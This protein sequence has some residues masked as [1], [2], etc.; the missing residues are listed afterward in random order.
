[1]E[2]RD[3]NLKRIG[4]AKA[5]LLRLYRHD[6]DSAEFQRS[7]ER[8]HGEAA[9][10]DISIDDVDTEALPILE[11]NNFFAPNTVRPALPVEDLSFRDIFLAWRAI[12]AEGRLQID[13]RPQIHLG[14]IGS[15]A[16]WSGSKWVI[17]QKQLIQKNGVPCFETHYHCSFPPGSEPQTTRDH[18]IIRDY[19]RWIT[20]TEWMPP[21]KWPDD[22]KEACVRDNSLAFGE[23]TTDQFLRCWR[24]IYA[25]GGLAIDT[26]RYVPGANMVWAEWAGSRWV[27]RLQRRLRE[28]ETGS[29]WD[30][31][32]H[33]AF[34]PGGEPLNERDREIIRKYGRWITE[35]EWE[36][37]QPATEAKIITTPQ[38][39]PSRQ[40]PWWWP[41]RAR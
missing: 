41:W 19:G 15:W 5:D 30:A 6:P 29:S 36:P 8:L 1:M 12:H 9:R 34:P 21:P 14:T 31:Y 11:R 23:M 26:T 7:I 27:S 38:P 3:G 16:E 17:A 2:G 22:F 10:L 32:L 13:T 25:E 39:A 40:R 33:L 35:T 28:E 18:E 20:E 24:A 37:P 4:Q